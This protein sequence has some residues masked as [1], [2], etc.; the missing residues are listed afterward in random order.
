[1]FLFKLHHPYNYIVGGVFFVK[2]SLSQTYLSWDAFGE[3]NGTKSLRKLNDVIGKYI[4]RNN[5]PITNQDRIA[6]S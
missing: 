1:M 2:Y 5:M 4:A 3:E 6:L